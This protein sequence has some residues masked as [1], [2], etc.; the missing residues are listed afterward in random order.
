MTPQAARP[1]PTVP[2][3]HSDLLGANFATLA[4]IDREGRPQLTEVWFLAEDGELKLSLSTGRQK[5][6]NL[7]ANR[8][9]SLFLLDLANPFRYLEVRGDAEI[10]PDS[11]YAFADRVGKKYGANLRAYD[12]PGESRVVVTV[13]PHRVNA[14][15]MSSGS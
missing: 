10:V 12:Q 1:T 11:D 5:T 15:D 14:V 7:S 9:C 3:S 6:K 13:R 2:P 4:T 8:A